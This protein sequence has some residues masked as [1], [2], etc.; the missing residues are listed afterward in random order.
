M[1]DQGLIHGAPQQAPTERPHGCP[2]VRASRMSFQ[3]AKNDSFR[4]SLFAW[5]CIQLYIWAS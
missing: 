4:D 3:A 1:E 5:E 2:Q